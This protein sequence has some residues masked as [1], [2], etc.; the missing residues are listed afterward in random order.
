MFANFEKAFFKKN[1]LDKKIP[2]EILNSLSENLPEGFIYTN[3]GNGAAG[4]SPLSG[5]VKLQGLNVVLPTDLPGNFKPQNAKELMEF[6]YRTQRQMKM[7]LEENNY[8]RINGTS[9]KIDEFINF[10]LT[11]ELLTQSEFYM[12]PQPF[13]PPFEIILEGNGIFKNITIQ[14]QPYEDLHRSLFKSIGK[15]AFDISYIIDEESHHLQFNFKLNI[16][17]AKNAEEVYE[18]LNLYISCI[19]GG[20]KLNGEVLPN[21]SRIETE[22]ESILQIIKFW[23]KVL[24]LQ[25][26]LKVEFIPETQT[27]H[28]DVILVEELHKSLI[29]KKPF[30]NNINI[31]ELTVN[32]VHGTNINDLIGVEGL[33]FQF[34]QKTSLT[35]LGIDLELYSIVGFFDFKVCSIEPI[36]KEKFNFKLKIEPINGKKI[37]QSILHFSSEEEA[38]EYR[39]SS[40]DISELQNAKQIVY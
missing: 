38:S 15:N 33:S 10:P 19:S 32:G 22:E 26:Y 4:I 28:E 39:V 12:V 11:D 27:E 1:E 34:I 20:I 2:N 6:M 13:Q 21:P 5:E 35:L 29:E 40:K 8:I 24:D 31:N 17:N 30:R 18:A 7:Q 14:R 16:E 3:I 25:D 37:Y 36:N 23:E 9:F